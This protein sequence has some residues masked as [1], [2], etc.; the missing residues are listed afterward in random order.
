EANGTVFPLVSCPASVFLSQPHPSILSYGVASFL[1]PRLWI[2][3]SSDLIG[4]RGSCF[5][6]LERRRGSERLRP[7]VALIF[8]F[9]C[10][11]A[12]DLGQI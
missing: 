7:S 3:D 8:C 6:S 12:S 1:S 4:S 2:S 5:S 9:L 11:S 10:A